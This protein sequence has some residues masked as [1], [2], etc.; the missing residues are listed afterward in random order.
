MDVE[1]SDR[2]LLQYGSR[3][4]EPDE[5]IEFDADELSSK[6]DSRRSSERVKMHSSE[7]ACSTCE[8][9]KSNDT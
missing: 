6:L 9:M 7:I 1:S 2:I 4:C 8:V 5:T 3:D